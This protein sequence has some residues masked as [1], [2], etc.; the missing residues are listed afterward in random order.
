MLRSLQAKAIALE[1][2]HF[3]K[4]LNVKDLTGAIN[5]YQKCDE[6]IGIIRR[7][8]LNEQDKLKLGQIAK[9]VYESGIELSLIL[10]EQSFNKKKYLNLAFDFCERSKSA[11]LLEAI[12]ES[13]AK[14][15]AGIPTEMIQLED[16]LKDE[17]FFLRATPGPRRK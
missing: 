16:S 13:K 7:K 11:V 5:T 6:L 8:R 9:E 1:A 4:S 3:E 10:S 15:F 17:I 14:Q 12:T 2:L